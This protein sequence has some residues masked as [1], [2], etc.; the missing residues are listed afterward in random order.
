M[1]ED[2]DPFG[3]ADR[4]AE[5]LPKDEPPAP[6]AVEEKP[7]PRR[8]RPPV[9]G[10]VV[11]FPSRP[12]RGGAKVTP[13]AEMG[14]HVV[15]ADEDLM[16]AIGDYLENKEAA[17]AY[18]VALTR[19]KDKFKDKPEGSYRVGPYVVTIIHREGG[20]LTIPEWS[21]NVISKVEGP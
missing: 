14:E 4:E 12:R 21:S 5:Q 3:D 20:G 7:K 18:R 2:Q 16:I 9:A 8:G 10:T 11:E 15:L 13:Q 6:A 19:M 1:A 17:K